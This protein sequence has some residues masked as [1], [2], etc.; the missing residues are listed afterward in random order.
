MSTKND[1]ERLA[2]SRLDNDIRTGNYKLR[3]RVKG[4]LAQVTGIVDTLAEKEQV[5]QVLSGIDGLKGVENGITMSTDG[6]IIDEDVVEEVTEELNADPGVD[7]RNV[8][9]RSVKGNVYLVGTVAGPE[10][11]QAAIRAASRARGVKSVVSQIKIGGGRYD[12]DD[13]RQIFHH[14]VNNDRELGEEVDRMDFY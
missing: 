14:Q 5:D 13:L 8:G 3:V 12:T 9:A 10:E 11:E 2:Q 6:S 4:G 7:L 1:L